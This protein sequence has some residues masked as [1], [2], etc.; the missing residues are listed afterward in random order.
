MVQREAR[1]ALQTP[2]RRP[3]SAAQRD[4]ELSKICSGFVSPGPANRAIYRVVLERLL[5]PGAGIP[6]PVVSRQQVRDAVEAVKPGYQDVFR[7][8]RELQGEEGLY[9]IIKSGANYQLVSLAVGA[10]REPRRALGG[11]L[12]LAVS[13]RQGGRC[14]VCGVPIGAEGPRRAELDH[15]VPRTRGGDNSEANL[16]GL[17]TA[18]N[19]SKS[20]QCTNCTLDCSTCGW[21]FPEKYRP[22]K[23]RPD[24]ILRLNERAK[25]SNQDV[26]QLANAVLERELRAPR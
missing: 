13:L 24:I 11:D 3:L 8:V 7:R 19:N 12:A 10:K 22:V 20:T 15:R 18:C 16:Q 5:P 1:Q 9:G 4:S 14:A 2:S 17:C 25:E 6:G 26:D 21:A 23:L